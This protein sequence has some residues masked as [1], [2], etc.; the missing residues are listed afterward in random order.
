MRFLLA[1]SVAVIAVWGQPPEDLVNPLAGKPEA[2]EA[3]RKL[4][5]QSCSGCHGP[6]AEGGRGPRL[7]QRRGISRARN[8]RLFDSIKNGIRGSD[9]P[10]LPLPD[11]KIWELVSYVKSIN[12]SA[13]D[14]PLTGDP[15]VGDAVFHGKAGCTG[16]HRIRGKG[17]LLGPDL[18]NA[19][20]TLSLAQL[21]ESILKPSERVADGYLG[22]TVIARDGKR[23]EGVSRDNTNYS[24]AVMTASG[25]LRLL[26]KTT[27]AEI[28]FHRKS[29][30]P[31]DYSS[32][33]SNQELD[34]L[35]AYLGRQAV[36]PPQ[37]DPPKER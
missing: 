17:G 14:S 23:V 2:V 13:W 11:D 4:Y 28:V 33:L 31:D 8:R 35:V 20:L 10:P 7:V 3:G 16:C 1:A 29:P 37:P 30:M 27:L 26:S 32:R 19:G 18:S 34:D 12:A 25:E 22:V 9:M 21:R 36:R 5:L 15:S 24:I 6:N